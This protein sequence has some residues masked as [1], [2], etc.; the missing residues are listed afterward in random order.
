[1]KRL[2]E[3]TL[4]KNSEIVLDLEPG[5]LQYQESTDE[6]FLNCP[7]CGAFQHVSSWNPVVHEDGTVTLSP[8]IWH[9]RGGNGDIKECGAHYF[10]RKSKIEWC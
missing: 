2:A 7:K 4:V 1:M 9:K 6:W 5:S 8:S 10:I 3:I